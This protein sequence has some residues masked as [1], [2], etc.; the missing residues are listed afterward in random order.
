MRRLVAPLAALGISVS[1]AAC[2]PQDAR[3]AEAAAVVCG[4]LRTF[5][6][7]LVEIVNDSVAGIGTLPAGDRAPAIA[8]GLDAAVDALDAWDHRIDEMDLPAVDEADRIRTQ[9]HDGVDRAL[10]ELEDQRSQLRLGPISD[11]DVQGAVGEWFNSIEKVMSVLEPEIF[12]FE[13]REFKQAFLD[14][15]DC[16]NVIQQFVNE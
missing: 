9:L 5:D 11:G 15:A 16:R 7:A 2:G 10:A 12:K 13:R 8:A 1:L 3:D 6:D 14:E 4:E